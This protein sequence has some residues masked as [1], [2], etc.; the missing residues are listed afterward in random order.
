MKISI[1]TVVMN[2][3]AEMRKTLISLR[4][5]TYQD[6]EFVVIDG[7]SN[8]GTLNLLQNNRDII[9]VLVSE[10]DNGLYY[11]M[12]KGRELASGDFAIFI[13]S[14]DV[15]TKKN[16]LELVDKEITSKDLI[17]YGNVILHNQ[18]KYGKAVNLHHQSVFY[19]RSYYCNSRYNVERFNIMAEADFTR[20]ALKSHDLQYF[21]IDILY[22][23]LNGFGVSYYKSWKGSKELIHESIALLKEVKGKVSI[24][25]F[26]KIYVVHTIKFLLFKVGGMSL[27]SSM[28]IRNGVKSKSPIINNSI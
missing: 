24:I 28:I 4:E 20:R 9:D 6:F 17:Y 2:S 16:I 7:N 15:F 21:D 27:L 8:D 1:I 5:Q 3:L 10:K 18:K 12:N 13:N 14:G 22:S 23:E 19:P 11:A 25:S 26:V